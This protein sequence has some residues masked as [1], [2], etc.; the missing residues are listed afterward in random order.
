MKNSTIDIGECGIVRETEKAFLLNVPGCHSSVWVPKSQMQNVVVEDC[1][2]ED[3]GD[4]Y[5]VRYLTALVPAWLAGRFPWKNG[6]VPVATR[7]L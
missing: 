5:T 3:N 6:P 4:K 1:T 7:P 2:I